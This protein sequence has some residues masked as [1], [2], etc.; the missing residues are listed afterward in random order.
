MTAPRILVADD[1]PHI[2]RIIK[3]KLEQGPFRVTL[4]YDGREAVEVADYAGLRRARPG[5]RLALIR[6]PVVLPASRCL[7]HVDEE[8]QAEPDHVEQRTE[9]ISDPVRNTGVERE[10]EELLSI[11]PF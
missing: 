10:R 2:G 4:A 6:S 5:W 3:M 1:E 8:E 9:T 7:Q 11:L